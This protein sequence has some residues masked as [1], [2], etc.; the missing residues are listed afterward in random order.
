VYDG[1]NFARIDPQA[2]SVA[3]YREMSGVEE[4]M[5]RLLDTLRLQ[6]HFQRRSPRPGGSVPPIR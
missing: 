6:A 2:K 3:E 4:G 5:K 1:E